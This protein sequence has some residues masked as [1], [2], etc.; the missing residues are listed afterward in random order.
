MGAWDRAGRCAGRENV[1]G[2]A[3]IEPITDR[4]MCASVDLHPDDPPANRVRPDRAGE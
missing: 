3:E 4:K 1:S 2:Q